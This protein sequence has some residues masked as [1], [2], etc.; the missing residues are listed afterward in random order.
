[1]LG[2]LE[3]AALL[4]GEPYRPLGS[5]AFHDAM[6]LADVCPSA[7]LFVPSH[8]GISHNAAED[9]P[10]AD[11][12]AGVRALAATLFTLADAD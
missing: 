4:T 1:V 7:M 10:E 12:V 9:T 2:V 3:A 5:G 11:L 6:Y 8:R